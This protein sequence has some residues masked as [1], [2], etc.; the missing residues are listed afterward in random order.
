[1]VSSTCSFVLFRGKRLH[2]T[3]LRND[4]WNYCFM[5]PVQ[6]VTHD[7]VLHSHLV[8]QYAH[9]KQ[10]LLQDMSCIS[11]HNHQTNWHSSVNCTDVFLNPWRTNFL[12]GTSTTL[13]AYYLPGEWLA[14]ISELKSCQLQPRC[15]QCHLHWTGFEQVAAQCDVPWFS[16]LGLGNWESLNYWPDKSNID[17]L[18]NT[19]I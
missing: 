2:C 12:N 6:W 9:S 10:Q 14:C 5:W 18:G 8:L 19:R 7:S 16:T 3:P 15:W 4:C 11:V 13:K 17:N 1:M